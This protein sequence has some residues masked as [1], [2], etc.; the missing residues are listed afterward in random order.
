LSL[1]PAPFSAGAPSGMTSARRQTD[2]EP[3]ASPRRR[4]SGGLRLAVSFGLLAALLLLVDLREAWRVVVEARIELLALMLAAMIGERLF[5]A[6][7]WLLLLRVGEPGLGYGP[8]LRIT[9]IS[10]WLGTFL[11]G[12]VG[13]EALRVWYLS[14]LTADLP[15]A[16]ASVVVERL[17]GLLALLGLI[18]LGLLLAPIALPLAV[19]LALLA[20][21]AALLAFALALAHPWPRRLARRLL[22]RPRLARLWA[23]LAGL[24]RRLDAYLRR[25]RVLAPALALALAFQGLRVLTVVI[26]AAALGIAVD[27]LLLAV[28]VPI[29]ILVAL[30]PI[31]IGGLGPREAAYVALLGLAGVAPEPALVLALL[32]EAMNIATLLPGAV[33]YARGPLPHRA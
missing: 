31:S 2:R 25:P 10:T 4:L 15:L 8:V 17:C 23:S 12:G 1:R 22:T 27:P 20:A 19:E 14:R 30:L 18:G 13:I 9:L 3:P 7:R 21:L 16:L 6:W 5:A 29:T 26:G 28:I 33:L 32:R 11:P 24:E